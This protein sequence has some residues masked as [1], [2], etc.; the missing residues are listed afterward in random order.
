MQCVVSLSANY[1]FVISLQEQELIQDAP[2]VAS[3]V[4]TQIH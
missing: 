3:G 1:Y 2:T 4:N